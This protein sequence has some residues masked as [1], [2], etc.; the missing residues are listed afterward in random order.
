MAM[1]KKIAFVACS[2]FSVAALVYTGALAIAMGGRSAAG[3]YGLLFKNIAVLFVYS[4]AM[5][6]LDSVFTLKV[7]AAAKRVIHALALYACTLAAGLI[8]A[9]PGKDARQ[10]VLFIFILTLVYT[11]IYTATVLIMRIIK[12]AR[13]E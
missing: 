1:F 8:M 12:K 6:A 7:S 2:F 11:V 4:W 10:I 13:G 5:G 3:A 9:D